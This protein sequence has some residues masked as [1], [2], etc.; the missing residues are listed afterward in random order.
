MYI[1]DCLKGVDMIMH[2]DDLIAT[3]ITLGTSELVSINELVSKVEKIAG[4][5]LDREYD[6][7]APRGVAGRNSDNGL[8]KRVLDWEPNTSLD[9]GLLATYKWIEAQFH[10]RKSGQRVVE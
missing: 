6:L 5:K 2:C 9:E 4:V 3:R 8:I 7:S 10:A 1:E